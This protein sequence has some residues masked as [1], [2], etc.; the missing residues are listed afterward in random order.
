[1]RSVYR[2]IPSVTVLYARSMGPYLAGASKAWDLMG[3]YLEK[4]KVRRSVRVSYGLFRDNPRITAPELV[5]CDA[6]IPL[7]P[8]LEADPALGIGRQTLPGGAFAVHTHLGSHA[9]LGELFSRLYREEVPVRG[10]TVDFERPFL[11]TYLTDPKVTREIHRRTEI[12]VPFNPLQAHSLIGNKT[13]AITS[14]AMSMT[15]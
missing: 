2:H 3:S 11:A 8:G 15:A 9:A 14:S 10:L 6:C 12:C 5:R 4:H 7:I 1:M 13:N